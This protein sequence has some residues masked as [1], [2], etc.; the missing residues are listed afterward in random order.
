VGREQGGE[1]LPRLRV[2]KF[3][4]GLVERNR[5]IEAAEVPGWDDSLDGAADQ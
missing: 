3:N 1:S 2:K 4:D 5:V